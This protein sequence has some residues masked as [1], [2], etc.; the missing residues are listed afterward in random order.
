MTDLWLNNHH[1]NLRLVTFMV[2]DLLG[3]C[4]IGRV[5]KGYTGAMKLEQITFYGLEVKN[6]M[7]P[8]QGFLGHSKLC[9]PKSMH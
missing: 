7:T 3:A 9:I 5:K 1:E 8:T 2:Q 6:V 4:L